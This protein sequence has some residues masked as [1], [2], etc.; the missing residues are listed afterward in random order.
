MDVLKLDRGWLQF[1]PDYD[2]INVGWLDSPHAFTQADTPCTV[3]EALLEIVA[4]PPVNVM[5]GFHRC[6][7]CPR[8]STDSM[9]SI[10]HRSG[11]VFLGHSEIRVP[12]RDG[13]MFAAPTLIVHYVVEHS[14]RPPGEFIAAVLEYD[15]RWMEE[16]SRW[17][18]ADAERLAVD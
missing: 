16:P 12:S 9:I 4:G 7:F 11:P 17:I 5:R 18:P 14:Y 13:V 10:G 3:V 8:G 6:T 2:R 15:H 1:Q